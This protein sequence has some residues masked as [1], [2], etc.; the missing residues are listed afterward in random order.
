M[1]RSSLVRI[2]VFTLLVLV[3]YSAIASA[4]DAPTATPPPPPPKWEYATVHAIRPEVDRRINNLGARGWELVA[5]VKEADD[6]L[7][8]AYLKR[9]YPS[10]R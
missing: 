5:V 2:A 6:R 3:L 10:G 9:S 1:R 4:Q 7:Y 8:S